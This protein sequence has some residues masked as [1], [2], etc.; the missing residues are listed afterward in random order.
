MGR[1]FA[2]LLPCIKVKTET[3]SKGKGLFSNVG[4]GQ[5]SRIPTG[6]NGRLG[7]P[8]PFIEIIEIHG[9]V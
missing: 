9:K 6:I 4:P 3:S 8:K 7:K 1:L 5:N 2:I